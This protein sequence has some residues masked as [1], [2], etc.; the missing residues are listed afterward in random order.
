M[1]LLLG[2]CSWG[3]PANS[4]TN[5]IV[6]ERLHPAL[7]GVPEPSESCIVPVSASAQDERARCLYLNR[8]AQ[9]HKPFSPTYATAEEWPVIVRRY[10]PRAALYGA[11]RAR[12]LHWLQ[13]NAR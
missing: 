9:C 7:R 8:C 2:A 11:D 1:L 5:S 6:R 4:G 12:V 3:V 10:A 13:A